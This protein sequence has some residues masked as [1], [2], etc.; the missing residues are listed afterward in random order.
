MLPSMA[1]GGEAWDGWTGG[2]CPA[3][4]A[5]VRDGE[6]CCSMNGRD[7]WCADRLGYQ[8]AGRTV[9]DPIRSDQLDRLMD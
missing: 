8:H 3:I 2:T 7:E 9:D 1:K 6:A 4:V 5:V